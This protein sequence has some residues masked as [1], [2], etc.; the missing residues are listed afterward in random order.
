[1]GVLSEMDNSDNDKDK[2]KKEKEKILK[3]SYKD[4]FKIDNKDHCH[5]MI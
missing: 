2:I 4:R 5:F 3:G 1:M